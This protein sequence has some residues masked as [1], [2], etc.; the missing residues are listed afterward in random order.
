MVGN[1][2]NG[3]YRNLYPHKKLIKKISDNQNSS[4]DKNL[5]PNF[6]LIG[7]FNIFQY[8]KA[9]EKILES[10]FSLWHRARCI[11]RDHRRYHYA[12]LR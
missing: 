5:Q 7:M 9:V 11:P 2:M 1:M 3:C 6:V 4:P 8:E 10:S 12:D